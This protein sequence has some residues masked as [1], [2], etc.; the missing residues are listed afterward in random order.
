MIKLL[1]ATIAAILML[2]TAPLRAEPLTLLVSA[3]GSGRTFEAAAKDFKSKTGIEV[4]AIQYPY[5][6][7]REK[8]LLELVGQTGNIDIVSIDGSIWLPELAQFLEPLDEASTDTSNIIP[9]M[10]DLFRSDDKLLALPVRI[11]GWVLIYR[12]DLFDAAGLQPP[13]TWEEFSAA[14]NALT[15]DGVYGF[16]PALRQGNYLVVQWIPFLFGHGGQILNEDRTT[17]AFNSDAG[18]KATKYFIDLVRSGVVPPGA[19]SYEQSD[20]I[21]AISQGIG[22]MALTYSPYFLNMNDPKES[23]VAGKLDISPFLPYD[24]ASGLSTGKTLISGWGFGVAASS[25]HKEE[26]KQFI[27]FIASDEEQKKLA[28]E[29]NNA[30]TSAAVYKDPDYLAKYPAAANVLS[31]L[32]SAEDRPLIDNWTEVEDILARELSAAVSGTKTPEQ[33]LQD[34]EA[35]VNAALK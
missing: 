4:N 11:A 15:K 6:E 22:A 27:E 14:A 9:S 25:R 17:A 29:N 13:R 28:V 3:G 31:A 24:P 7:V 12:K 35:G 1:L 10:V 18:K 26:A 16:A 5:A 2:A 34:A 33:A 19:A 23:K 20:I 8:Q 21:T 32:G 30:P